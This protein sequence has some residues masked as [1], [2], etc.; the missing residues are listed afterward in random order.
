MN[1]IH[2]FTYYTVC[3]FQVKVGSD[4]ETITLAEDDE[5]RKRREL[6]ARRPSYR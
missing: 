6:L 4:G 3:I 1:S 5:S 2:G